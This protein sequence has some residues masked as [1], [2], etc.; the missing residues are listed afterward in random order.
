[1]IS[2][3][4][5]C[6]SE[7]FR[8]ASKDELRALT[9][10]LLTGKIAPEELAKYASI[11]TARAKSALI[12]WEE[13]GIFEGGRPL[14][15]DI[16]PERLVEEGVVEEDR[17]VVAKTI[18]SEELSGLLEQAAELMEKPTLNDFEVKI[19]TGL[20]S[21]YGLSE[22]YICVLLSDIAKRS[23]RPTVKKLEM[24]ALRFLTRGIDTTEALCEFFHHRDNVKESERVVRSVIG[25]TGRTFSPSEQKMADRWIN[26]YGYGEQMILLAYDFATSS[27]T[28]PTLKYLDPILK[29]WYENGIK[30]ESEAKA[31]REA[32]KTEKKPSK[33]QKKEPPRYGNFDPE[34]AFRRALERSYGE[35]SEV[36]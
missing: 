24:E 7:E 14:I 9:V 17:R 13:V 8:S 32:H 1:M 30:T 2:I 36:K 20:Y 26:E 22:E 31:Y 3:E 19:I 15:E 27:T 21:Q 34:E 12:L 11:S 29:E 28:N 35:E 6:E 4:K 25:I 18:Q 23:T 33:K 16:Y 5:L 10:L